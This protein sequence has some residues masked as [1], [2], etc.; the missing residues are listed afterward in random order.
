MVNF[1]ER[2]EKAETSE[3]IKKLKLWLFQEQVR[4]QAQKEEL[5]EAGY[6]LQRERKALERERNALNMR[7]KSE[8]R[9]FRN[10][11]LF[12]AEKQKIIED[13]FRQLALDKKTLEC[14]RL[15]LE[16]EKERLRRERL[17]GMKS[18]RIDF[19][20]DGENVFFG[21][22]DNERALKKRY[23]DLLK[24]FHPDNKDGDTKTLLRIQT[25]YENI[26]SELEY[27]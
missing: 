2:L 19:I 1:D 13:A 7:A 20:S 18:Q 5:V 9:R 23:K 8:Q 10:N 21:G 4:I 27:G 16:Y 12:M 26:R 25:E 15:N 17:A 22:V 11:E 14:E 6:G 3:E 24:I